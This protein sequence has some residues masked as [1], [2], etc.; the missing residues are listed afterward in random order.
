[1]QDSSHFKHIYWFIVGLCVFGALYTVAL[2][3]F[4]IPKGSE[5]FAD[6]GHVFWLSTAVAGGI[7]YLIGSSFKNKTNNQNAGPAI[8][9]A[10]NVTVNNQAEQQ[11][12]GG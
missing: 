7:G 10:E 9:T 2:T 1:M 4:P 8:E 5:R 3:F 6:T 11:T 12:N